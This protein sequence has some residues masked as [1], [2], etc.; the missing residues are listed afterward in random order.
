MQRM[1][2]PR[3]SRR[4][5]IRKRVRELWFADPH[6]TLCGR[7][8]FLVDEIARLWGVPL[9]RV[10]KLPPIV[11]ESMATLD[12]IFDRLNPLRRVNEGHERTRLACWKC[13]NEL[14][15]QTLLNFPVEVR[16]MLSMH[17]GRKLS[18]SF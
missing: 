3:P 7:P 16:R 2:L 13:N 11:I 15:R 4:N 10:C 17:R 5:R 12:H 18:L 14:G 1:E 8:T 9:A 6:C